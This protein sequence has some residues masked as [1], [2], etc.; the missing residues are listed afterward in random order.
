MIKLGI[1]GG[2]GAGKSYVARLLTQEFGVPVY[3]CDR[4]A[5]RI[6]VEN[7]GVRAG[8][9]NL[10]GADAYAADGS[11]NRPVI[12]RFLFASP[13]H[14]AQVN[15]VVH[16]AVKADVR[17][18]FRQLEEQDAPPPV[19]AME[20]A[21]LV[22]AGFLDVVDALLIVEAPTSL[23]MARVQQRDG[24]S[25]EQVARRMAVQADDEQRRRLATYVIVNDGRD[26]I[27]QISE[28]PF[29]ASPNHT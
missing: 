4:E 6:M 13:E 5:K 16:P 29:L 26:L 23:R 17:H 14:A 8:I 21:I 10:V 9:T 12:A 19:A 18:W 27:S 7:E 28:L 2:I 15:A 1:T 11:L 22:E 3:D 24:A 25:S 20:S